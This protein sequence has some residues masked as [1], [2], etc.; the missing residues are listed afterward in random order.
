MGSA[1]RRSAGAFTALATIG[2][3]LASMIITA[4]PAFANAAD[5]LPTTSGIATV[6]ANGDITVNVSGTW[7]WMTQTC[8]GRFGTG[9][10]VSWGDPNAPGNPV[11]ATNP[12]ILVGTPTDNTVHFDA[13]H[14]LGTCDVDKHPTGNWSD[15]HTYAAGTDI[16]KICVNMYDL[17]KAPTG[18]AGDK[19]YTA[20]GP[21]HNKDNSVET[22]AFDPRIDTNRYCFQPVFRQDHPAIH[23]VKGG[24]AQVHVGDTITYTFEVTNIGDV[25]LHNVALTDAKCDS[26]ATIVAKTGT[27][28]DVLDLA[29][30]WFYRCPHVVK[31]T[32]ADPLPNTAT[33]RGLDPLDKTVTDTDDHLVDIVHP[34]ITVVKS[35][36]AT[37]TAGQVITYSFKVT[38][39]G[40]NDLQN[41]QLNDDKLGAVGTVPFLA[42][43]AS[44]TL[45]KTYTVPAGVAVVD[46]TVIACGTDSLALKVCDDDKHHL[47]VPT[48]VL[49][50]NFTRG[51]ELANTGANL[52]LRS[53]IS[54]LLLAGSVFLHMLYRRS[55]PEQ[56]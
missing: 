44:A 47:D 7:K 37:A 17:H 5:P 30:H 2:L 20:G 3:S 49:G 14:P 36:P 6:A 26:A 41:V 46:N 28:D 45:T 54:L 15:T 35:G 55:R 50:V 1:H 4:S 31:A 32:D 34:A 11:P 27:G 13:A 29:D 10:A 12:V 33:V 23:I 39:S 25:P 40:D 56:A 38:N 22:N 9:W 51:G 18:A 24:P 52:F 48:A 19:E 53:M 43:G 16:G 21:S 8:T 42:V